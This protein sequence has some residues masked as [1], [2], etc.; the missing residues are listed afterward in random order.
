M[1]HQGPL[2]DVI[3]KNLPPQFLALPDGR[4]M[5]RSDHWHRIV[6]YNYPPSV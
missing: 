2:D 3:A 6:Y 5:K 1:Y 4:Q